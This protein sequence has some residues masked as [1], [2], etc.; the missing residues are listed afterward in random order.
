MS[1]APLTSS[2]AVAEAQSHGQSLTTV[3]LTRSGLAA[4]LGLPLTHDPFLAFWRRLAHG[5]A[6]TFDLPPYPLDRLPGVVLGIL[7]FVFSTAFCA[8]FA[9]HL[10]VPRAQAGSL[11]AAE[12]RTLRIGLAL[13]LMVSFLLWPLYTGRSGVMI[14]DFWR[15]ALGFR[16]ALLAWDVFVLRDVEEVYSWSI[17]RFIAHLWT[18][19]VEETELAEREK[20]EGR[21]RN[22]RLE[23]LK[24]MPRVLLQFCTVFFGLLYFVPTQEQIDNMPRLPYHLYSFLLGFDILFV[25]AFF[26]DGLLNAMGIL[27]NVEMAPMFDSVWKATSI[28]RFWST[29]NK[30]IT[31][32]LH[33]VIFARAAGAPTKY[34]SRKS[35]TWTTDTEA[36]DTTKKIGSNGQFARPRPKSLRMTP[37][38]LPAKS[39]TESTAAPLESA[40]PPAAKSGPF[41]KKALAAMA[42]FIVSGIFH[43]HITYFTFGISQFENFA[44]FVIN[45][46]AA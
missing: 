36:E 33:R 21:V 8:Y 16:S 17:G 27:L 6:R 44:F 35:S 28:T 39:P 29:W 10:L 15:P 13:P 3:W 32:I 22:A 34:S 38:E 5:N 24:V 42:A 12:S 9:Y 18:F 43:E 31:V 40:K 46:L 37:A 2:Q 19:P 23:G 11:K 1:D 41:Y 26:G 7:Y 45:G 20:A 25:L 30:A 14:F 4:K